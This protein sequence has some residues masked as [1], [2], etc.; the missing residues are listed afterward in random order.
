M[1]VEEPL[2]AV[3]GLTKVVSSKVQESPLKPQPPVV[4]D[5]P[6]NEPEF[7]SQRTGL[8]ITVKT[9]SAQLFRDGNMNF[10]RNCTVERSVNGVGTASGEDISILDERGLITFVKTIAHCTCGGQLTVP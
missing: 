4:S 3:E 7:T 10:L 5:K 6:Q 1:S 2:P 9:N 8:E